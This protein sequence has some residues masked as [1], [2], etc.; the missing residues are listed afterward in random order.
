[1]HLKVLIL[2]LFISNIKVGA[3]GILDPFYNFKLGSPLTIPLVPNGT[4]AE[5]RLNHFHGGLDL[6]TNEKEGL[7]AIAVADGYIARIKIAANG[8][9]NALYVVHPNGLTT[10]YGHL[11]KFVAPIQKY[12]K[13]QQYSKQSFE[14][15]IVIPK[16]LFSVKKGDTIAFTG[17]TGSSGGPHLHFEVRNTA[18]ECPINPQKYGITTKDSA[19]PIVSKIH[20]IQYNNSV[21]DGNIITKNVWLKQGKINDYGVAPTVIHSGNIAIAVEAF[22]QHQLT[23]SSKNGIY[24]LT[25]SCK[26]KV[27]YQYKNDSFCFDEQRYVHAMIDYEE[28]FIDGNDTYYLFKL[29]NNLFKNAKNTGE[30]KIVLLPNDSIVLDIFLK[31]FEGNTATITLPIK[32]DTLKNNFKDVLFDFKKPL[33]LNTKNGKINIESNTFYDNFFLQLKDTT[34]AKNKAL[35]LKGNILLPMH[36]P[37]KMTLFTD[38]KNMNK[39]YIVFLNEKNKKNYIKPTIEGNMLSFDQK[40]QGIFWVETDTIKPN[41]KINKEQSINN[42]WCFSVTDNSSLVKYN[43]Y[44]DDKWVL[45]QYDMKNDIMYY[46]ADEY[47]KKGKHSLKIIVSDSYQNTAI[48]TQS[49]IY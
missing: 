9:G 26:S 7:P 24:S 20:I 3:Q 2:I 11:S 25:L 17:N 15:D 18:T 41:I 29:P 48:F 37:A 42:K 28:K 19:A 40:E 45:L 49:I 27:L 8:Y 39:K 14:I 46:E 35:Q 6:K 16:F 30:G 1:M 23:K 31:D 33:F 43:A 10:V 5:P 22:D 21:Y 44:L 12:A 4:F 47:C 38:G 34:I 36:K 32:A 13:S